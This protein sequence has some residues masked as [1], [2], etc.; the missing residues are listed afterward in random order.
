MLSDPSPLLA[1]T[2]R[3][4]QC[5][6]CLPHCPTYLVREDEGESPRGRIAL[7][8]AYLRGDLPAGSRLQA[9]LD[10]CLGC[11][12]CEA[13]CPAGVAY[14][15]LLDGTREAFNHE[16][17]LSP[18]VQRLLA[19]VGD[20]DELR[21]L[22]RRLRAAQQSGAVWLARHSGLLRPDTRRLSRLLPPLAPQ[23]PWQDCYRARGPRQGS[24]ALFLGCVAEVVDRVTLTDAITVL[25]H[26]GYDVH[27]PKAQGCC[28]ALHQHNGQP[29]TARELRKR[30]RHAFDQYDVEAVI[31]TASACGAELTEAT[32]APATPVRDVCEF[33][34]TAQWPPTT[35]FRSWPIRIAVQEPCS[36]RYPL[37]QQ[38]HAYRLLGR[39]PGVEPVPLPGN[40]QCCG[41]AGSYVLNEPAMADALGDRKIRALRDSGATLLATSN[42][43]CAL[44]LR[45]GLLAAGLHVK[46]L[47]PVSVL[48]SRLG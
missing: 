23:T 27:V 19:T 31:T 5:G 37:R 38:T 43:G 12:A 21:K 34:A 7:M 29:G 48:A 30:N 14:G 17:T 11:R 39:I 35:R 20:R 10:H 6:L 9:H 4:V 41:A 32:P 47:H 15:R 26:C 42:T 46:V 45:A 2:Q 13:A 22:G 40:E 28:G 36:L 24:V 8:N 25:N 18:L 3:C 44:H 1:E 33:L 16:R